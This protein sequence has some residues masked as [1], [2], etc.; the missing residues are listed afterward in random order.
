[1][2]VEFMEP[3]FGGLGFPICGWHLVGWDPQKTH[4]HPN[5]NPIH[6]SWVPLV[7]RKSFPVGCAQDTGNS[8]GFGSGSAHVRNFRNV[9]QQQSSLPT[10]L[11][12]CHKQRGD[13]LYGRI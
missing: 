7:Y 13:P 9:L 2:A 12:V 11:W 1:M 8:A 10:R 6:F 4:L 5:P 3:K